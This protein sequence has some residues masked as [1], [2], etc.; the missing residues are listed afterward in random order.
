MPSPRKKPP[1]VLQA[2]FMPQEYQERTQWRLCD[3][4]YIGYGEQTRGDRDTR[5]AVMPVIDGAAIGGRCTLW[6]VPQ[7]Q[8]DVKSSRGPIQRRGVA[9]DWA[10]SNDAA[11]RHRSPSRG[12][13]AAS[14]GEMFENQ[15]LGLALERLMIEREERGSPRISEGSLDDSSN[16]CELGKVLDTSAHSPRHHAV[17]DDAFN[18]LLHVNSR[19]RHMLGADGPTVREPR[20]VELRRLQDIPTLPFGHKVDGSGSVHREGSAGGAP[21]GRER[22]AR[23]PHTPPQ[24]GHAN[25][26]L[27]KVVTQSDD[28]QA[29]L[30]KMPMPKLEPMPDD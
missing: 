8:P 10:S 30:R 13:D 3:Q 11:A 5:D 14:D 22:V 29:V 18:A 2:V 12:S 15:R 26:P 28:I 27:R 9:Y 24:D 20:A 1:R 7:V 21:Y 25:L 16:E 6:C 23:R 17:S 19:R 4:A